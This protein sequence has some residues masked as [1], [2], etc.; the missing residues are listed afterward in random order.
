MVE[1]LSR[2][3]VALVLAFG[4][5]ACSDDDEPT[6]TGPDFPVQQ[7]EV[8]KVRALDFPSV[9]GVQVNAWVGENNN[10]EATTPQPVVILVHDFTLDNQEWVQTPHYVEMLRRGY[11]VV[12]ID[13]RGHGGTALPD[14]RQVL[15]LQDLEETYLDVEAA[16][17]WLRQQPQ[18]DLNRVAVVGTG[19]GGNVSFVSKGAF[20][21][22]IKTAVVLSPGLWVGDESLPVV[23]GSGLEDFTPQSVLYMVGSED[24]IPLNDG[25]SLSFPLFAQTL[26][27]GTSEPKDLVVVNQSTAHG[28]ALLDDPAAAATFFRWLD[29][30]L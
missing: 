30:H 29:D 19:V 13:M 12:A 5:W 16:L 27:E 28:I 18:A 22:R 20:S 25:S 17:L 14:D 24:V 1:R 4:I 2:P 26:A 6:I 9:D 15:E 11:F 21:Q 23:V 10:E 3:L 8:F 7:G